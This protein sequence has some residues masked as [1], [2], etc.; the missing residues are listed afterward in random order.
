MN[1]RRSGTSVLRPYRTGSPACQRTSPGPL[2]LSHR[3]GN[4]SVPGLDTQCRRGIDR[5]TSAGPPGMADLARRSHLAGL[6]ETPG[7]RARGL[8]SFG[9]T[10][11]DLNAPG[12]V[13]LTI[14]PEQISM[15]RGPGGV[16][17]DLSVSQLIS[18]SPSELAFIVGHELGHVAQFQHGKTLSSNAEQDADLF[19]M[20]LMIF[21]GF[22]PY[23][24]AGALAKLNMV[25]G[26]AGPVGARVRRSP[27][28]HG[29]FTS[30]MDS[31]LSTLT[32]LAL[33]LRFRDF[34]GHTN[35]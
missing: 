15:R 1:L 31:M 29:S 3:F 9:I 28:P 16:Q 5:I 27:D 32:R 8:A 12:A 13:N 22:D 25:T 20:T 4:R 14:S 34:A 2:D 18:D 21:A 7:G 19:A 30:R 24:G 35:P 10:D 26:T 23:G 17:I 6:S 33:S 11:V